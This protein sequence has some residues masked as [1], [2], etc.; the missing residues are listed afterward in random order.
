MA[1]DVDDIVV[2]KDLA[3]FVHGFAR[4][5]TAGED[6]HRF[7]R[8]VLPHHGETR[9][10]RS[11]SWRPLRRWRTCV[12]RGSSC[13][14]M[15][16]RSGYRFADKNMRHS[17]ESRACPDSEGTGHALAMDSERCERP[18]RRALRAT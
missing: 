2:P 10:P 18:G 15:F 17:M 7:G 6:S 11:R 12:P 13:W 8:L 14:R 4:D 1:S 9:P 3:V 16:R 5:A